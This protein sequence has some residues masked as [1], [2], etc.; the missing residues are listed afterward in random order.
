MHVLRGLRAD[1]VA[2]RVSQLRWKFSASSD[3]P[4]GDAREASRDDRTASRR[5]GPR[6]A[7][8]ILRALSRYTAV[9]ALIRACIGWL[10]SSLVFAPLLARPLAS[11]EASRSS[12][13]C[14]R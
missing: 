5:C 3:P 10:H 4:G 2:Q 8:R 7:Q 14:F 9:A 11:R 1:L 6:L 12:P 13:M